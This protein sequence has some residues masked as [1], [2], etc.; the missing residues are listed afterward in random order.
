MRLLLLDLAKRDLIEGYRFYED[1]EAGLGAYFLDSLYSD[2]D[3]LRIYAGIHRKAY[4]GFHR[5]LSRRFPFAIYYTVEGEL[6]RVRAIVD[7]RKA[8][9]WIRGHLRSG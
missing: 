5:A 1:R 7:C 6:V 2:V 3:S 8:P 9:S 4:R